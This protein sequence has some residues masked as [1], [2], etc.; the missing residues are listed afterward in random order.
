MPLTRMQALHPIAKVTRRTLP[1][2]PSA[3][4]V[5]PIRPQPT[6]SRSLKTSLFQ[7]IDP[8]VSK[9]IGNIESRHLQL[10]SRAPSHITLVPSLYKEEGV[11]RPVKVVL[12]HPK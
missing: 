1:R 2:H 8:V 4:L 7:D 6:R 10:P 9:I 11:R 5:T 12:L 3:A